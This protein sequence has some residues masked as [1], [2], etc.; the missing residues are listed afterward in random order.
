MRAIQGEQ[1]ATGQG[2]DRRRP[3]HVVE[4]GDLPEAR[5]GAL[6]VAKNAVDADLHLA[7]GD[8]VEPFARLSLR[9]DLLA[10]SWIDG[11]EVMAEALQRV[12]RQRREDRVMAKQPEM[13]LLDRGADP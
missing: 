9:D 11:D 6:V 12:H 13:G 10:R 1:T 5:A 2:D 7:S 4:Q 3:R 8:Q